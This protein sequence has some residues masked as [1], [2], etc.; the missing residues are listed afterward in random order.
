MSSD[1]PDSIFHITTPE[2]WAAAAEAGQYVHPSL[3]NEGF[4]H[5][6]TSDELLATTRRHY[7]G[8]SGLIVL[9]ID[10]DQLTEG[11][12][13]WE[14]APSVGREFPHSYGPIP[15]DAVTATH[16]WDADENGLR[17]LPISRP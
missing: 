12:L 11:T 8:V 2:A 6:S 14:M 4:I 10:P 3:E 17:Q 16:G 15:T 13:V 5:M 7:E 1:Q 9:E